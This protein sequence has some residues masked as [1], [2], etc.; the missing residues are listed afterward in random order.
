MLKKKLVS[1]LLAAV[2]VMGMCGAAFAAEEEAPA[3]GGPAAQ[4]QAAHTHVYQVS[5]YEGV[6]PDRYTDSAHLYV[7][8]GTLHRCSCGDQYIDDTISFYQA[9]KLLVSEYGV[10]LGSNGETVPTY[11]HECVQCDYSKIKLTP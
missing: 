2:M 7:K 5:G 1:V 6:V 4:E 9:H 10:A 11:L 3:V 8:S